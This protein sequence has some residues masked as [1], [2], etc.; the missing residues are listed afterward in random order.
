M[1]P[2]S[3]ADVPLYIST[4]SRAA[5]LAFP[6]EGVS[7]VRG[8]LCIVQTQSRMGYGWGQGESREMPAP[9]RRRGSAQGSSAKHGDE[10]DFF[11]CHLLHCF[12][13]EKRE[14]GSAT[15]GSHIWL[16]ASRMLR[17]QRER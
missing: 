16:K 11:K 17:S 15:T 9:C 14:E 6:R 8:M 1:Q 10:D 3:L 4:N 7:M 2:T 12:M 5:L 13:S